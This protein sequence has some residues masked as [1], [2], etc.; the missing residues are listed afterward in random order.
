M[1]TDPPQETTPD[2]P[3]SETRAHTRGFLF[4]DLRGYTEF[5]DRRGDVA[6]AQLLAR[7]RVIVR[8]AV[9]RHEGAEIRTEGDG[10]YVVFPS[11]SSAVRCALAITAA[12]AD[13]GH[14]SHDERLRVA[15]GIHAGETAD[16]DEGYVGSAVNTAARIASVAREGEVLVSDTV[17]SLTRTLLPV[18]FVSRGV[19]RLKGLAEPI[20]IYRVVPAGAAVQRRAISGLPRRPAML[21]IGG[22]ALAIAAVTALGLA[23]LFGTTPTATQTP[24]NSSNLAGTT[25]PG[26]RP[27]QTSSASGTELTRAESDLHAR[28]P[29]SIGPHCVLD[30]QRPEGVDARWRCPSPL[31]SDVDTVWYELY[32]TRALL[33]VEVGATASDEGLQPGDCDVAAVAA[34]S[35]TTPL[36]TYAGRLLCFPRDGSSWLVWSYDDDLIVAIATRRDLDHEALLSWWRTVGPFL[37]APLD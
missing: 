26:V 36:G 12:A 10:F 5:V 29:G 31:G 7:Y 11:A 18:A 17:R 25:S 32:Q 8:H 33:D 16:T 9:A 21:A 24:R 4:A 22:G 19:T 2:A 35:W 13:E 14:G 27:E 1:A 34:D 20:H 23:A 28:I 3:S 15:I 30:R 6:A 37:R